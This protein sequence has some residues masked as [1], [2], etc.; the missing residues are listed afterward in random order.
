[1]IQKK[2]NKPKQIKN[3]SWNCTHKY[4]LKFST[5]LKT[6]RQQNQEQKS[7]LTSQN[8]D[9]NMPGLT[10]TISHVEGQAEP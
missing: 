2:F 1:M 5:L 9:S 3:E 8:L 7:Y 4:E 10:I 6:M